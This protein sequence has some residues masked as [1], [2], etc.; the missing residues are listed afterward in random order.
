MKQRTSE[1]CLQ[2]IACHRCSRIGTGSPC[3]RP[4]WCECTA[5]VCKGQRAHGKFPTIYSTSSPPPKKMYPRFGTSE[6]NQTQPFRMS[7]FSNHFALESFSAVRSRSP[8]ILWIR[9]ASW[10]TLGVFPVEGFQ[11]VRHSRLQDVQQAVLFDNKGGVVCKLF[12]VL[13]VKLDPCLGASLV[14]H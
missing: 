14:A 4:P 7:A 1:T 11:L 3:P 9:P 5:F 13:C 12:E 8:L 6:G 2:A 10:C